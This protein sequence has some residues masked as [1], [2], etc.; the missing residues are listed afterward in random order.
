M[1]D[2]QFRRLQRIDLL[3][4]AA[5]RLHGI[6]HG[7]QIHHRRHAGEILH[8]HARGA[9]GDLGVGL[10]LRIPVEQGLDVA[11]RDGLAV[12]VAQQV[13]QQYFERIGQPRNVWSSDWFSRKIS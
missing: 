6:A 8:Q 12:F 9:E 7:G 4:I 5:Q 1:I 3:R 13:F 2:D 11:A 10:G